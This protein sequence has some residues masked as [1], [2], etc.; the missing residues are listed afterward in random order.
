MA[1]AASTGSAPATFQ[2]QCQVGAANC[3]TD[4]EEP[5]NTLL[6]ASWTRQLWT[7]EAL[8]ITMPGWAQH[9]F[10]LGTTLQQH[11]FVTGKIRAMRRI[12]ILEQGQPAASVLPRET[13]EW[14]SSQEF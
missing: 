9:T 12:Q 10:H 6:E 13:D 2:W 1:A 14:S 8:E 7:A 4:Y 5:E 11:N 3:W